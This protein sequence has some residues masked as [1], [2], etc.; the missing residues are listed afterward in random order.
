MPSSVELPSELVGAVLG[1]FIRFARP[2]TRPRSPET[3]ATLHAAALVCRLWREPA[4]AELYAVP[5][6]RNGRMLQAFAD[7]LRSTPHGAL[8]RELRFDLECLGPSTGPAA[9]WRLLISNMVA[10]IERCSRMR[11]LNLQAVSSTLR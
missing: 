2:Y 10:V 3:V 5:R 8:V 1:S 9:E 7:T 11:M 4:M 6:L